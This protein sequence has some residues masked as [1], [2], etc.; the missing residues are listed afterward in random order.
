MSSPRFRNVGIASL[1]SLLTAAGA[2]ADPVT[3]GPIVLVDT[4]GSISLETTFT[5]GWAGWPIVG[6]HSYVGKYGG[7]QFTLTTPM[8]LSSVGAFISNCESIVAGVP[9]CNV[10]LPIMVQIRPALASQGYAPDPSRVI[11]TYPLSNDNDPFTVSFESASFRLAL[12]AATYYALFG[13]ADD[14]GGAVLD[15]AQEPLFRADRPSSGCSN[16]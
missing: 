5:S 3:T 2:A 4:I 13:P 11:A 10:G 1:V 9:D 14:E 12:E 16:R 15:Y 6:I 8:V 7:P